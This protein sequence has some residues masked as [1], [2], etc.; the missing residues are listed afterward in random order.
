MKLASV[1]SL[2]LPVLYRENIQVTSY[3]T[4]LL[5]FKILRKDEVWFVDK[6]ENISRIYPLENYPER[7]DKKIEYSYKDGEYGAIPVFE[8]VHGFLDE[9][10]GKTST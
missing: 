9:M 7:F 1:L 4:S 2:I 6:K 5:D 3:E 8:D 10:D